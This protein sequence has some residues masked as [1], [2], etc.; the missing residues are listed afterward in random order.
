[1]VVDNAARVFETPRHQREKC[2]SLINK[3][4]Q[5]ADQVIFIQHTDPAVWKERQ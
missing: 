4:T 2:V 5:A 3:L 1:M